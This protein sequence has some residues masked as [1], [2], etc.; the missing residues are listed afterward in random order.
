[1]RTLDTPKVISTN[2]VQQSID[3]LKLE[4]GHVPDVAG[5]AKVDTSITAITYRVGDFMNDGKP[6]RFVRRSVFH[7]DWPDEVKAAVRTLLA[8]AET[9]A[10]SSSLMDAGE[11]TRA[12]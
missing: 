5:G 7:A 9:D 11:S 6:K 1:M 2:I 12:L 4:V 3:Q 10:E 8:W